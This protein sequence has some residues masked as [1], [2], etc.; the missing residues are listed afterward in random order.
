MVELRQLR[1][2]VAVAE[3]LH[4]TRAAERLGITQ[5]PLSQQI[6]RLEAEL[7]VA[8]LTRDNRGVA[9]TEA[10][11]VFLDGSRRILAEEER[12]LHHVERVAR[13]EVG[14]LTIG[15]VSSAWYAFLPRVLRAFRRHYPDVEILA[16]S[17]ST[18]EQVDRLV[19]GSL[20]VALLRNPID[21]PGIVSE[22]V[23][24]DSLMVAMPEAHRFSRC[25]QI[26]LSALAQETLVILPR[27]YGPGGYDLIV[28]MCMEAGFKPRIFQETIEINAVV[29]LVNAGMGLSI[30]PASISNLRIEGIRY[31]PLAGDYPSWDLLMAW[32][33]CN[34]SPVLQVFLDVARQTS[35]NL[36]KEGAH[37]P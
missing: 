6:Q 34:V 27:R 13:G 1:Y 15:T 24:S 19:T 4:F 21:E 17:M 37:L 35:I 8:L 20:D 28:Q 14:S 33:E 9:L 3:E 26:E 22:V 2:F 36:R 5:P 31:V 16:N 30:V 7:G 32:R 23:I 12:A 10:G 11:K 25:K 18:T 29:G